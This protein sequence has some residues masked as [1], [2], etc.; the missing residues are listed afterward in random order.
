MAVIRRFANNITQTSGIYVGGRN[1]H[2]YQ[3]FDNL[4]NLKN[5]SGSVATCSNIGSAGGTW[6]R[7]ATLT[8]KNFGFNLPQYAKI[9]KIVIGYSQ[10]KFTYKGHAY[11]TLNAPLITLLNV[12][13][14]SSRGYAVPVAHTSFTKTYNVAPTPAQVNSPNF[15]VV[16]NYPANTRAD[17]GGMKLGYVWIE[18]EYEDLAFTLNTNIINDD[19][20]YRGDFF[21]VRVSLSN[22]SKA[23]IDYSTKVTIQI[24]LG[25]EFVG[26][27]SGQGNFNS[28]SANSYTWISSMNSNFETSAVF[29]VR[30][31]DTGTKNILLQETSTNISSRVSVFVKEDALQVGMDIPDNVVEDDH[32][33]MK[34]SAK[35]LSQ[36]NTDEHVY[37]QFPDQFTIHQYWLDSDHS[38]QIDSEANSFDWVPDT[39]NYSEE[40]LYIEA[41][42]NSADIFTYY[43]GKNSSFTSEDEYTIK[44]RP[45]ELTVPFFSML[46]LDEETCSRMGNG[47][48]YTASSFIKIIIGVPDL[49]LLE[50]YGYNYRFGIFNSE[51]GEFSSVADFENYV[52]S[53]TVWSDTI[54]SADEIA[55]AKVEFKYDENCPVI[56]VWTGEYLESDARAM[57]IQYSTPILIESEYYN[58]VEEAGLFPNPFKA[59]LSNED[60]AVT[61]LKSQLKSN[62]M[63]FYDY[64]V[65][66]L[67]TKDEIVIEGI[68][69]HLN[70]NSDNPCSLLLKLYTNGK[71]GERSLNISQETDEKVIGGKF[72]LWGLDFEDFKDLNNLEIELGLLN[73]FQ[74]DTYLEINNVYI[75]VHYLVLDWESKVKCWINGKDLR[76]Y[77]AFIQ[78]VEIPG[79]LD[80]KVLYHQ[81]KGSDTN[82]PYRSNITSKDIKIELDLLDCSLEDNTIFLERLSKLIRNERDSFNRPILN[83]IEFSHYPDQVFEF[84]QEKAIEVENEFTNYN[85]ELTLNV[86]SGTC[87]SKEAITSHAQGNN[88]SLTRVAPIIQ[89]IP[90]Q[91]EIT[92]TEDVSK[93]NFIIRLASLNPNDSLLV[94]CEKRKAVTLTKNGDGTFTETDV[95]DKVDWSS[96]W[97]TIEGEYRFTCGDSGNIQSVSF[98]ER[99]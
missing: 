97:F 59:L 48:S 41:S 22:L 58:G 68:S 43:I 69:V 31:V 81:V 47:I 33:L 49:S 85:C 95:T 37:I 26:K 21:D 55:E 6:N 74:H 40:T 44:V 11:P 52:L 71:V 32:F 46:E 8:F 89:L 30:C 51:I 4:Q 82:I 7:P 90:L 24:P 84:V 38:I 56:F 78:S 64:V 96:D 15:G 87:R 70:V 10:S 5:S 93:Q 73:P 62:N 18:I 65:G 80:S 60:F 12:A 91:E 61:E 27:V 35:T 3:T 23:R 42:V 14:C 29:R 19:E 2:K 25:L 1:P 76:Y 20:K 57:E 63:R 13:N 66:G 54:A 75:K 83:T 88:A 9:K 67:E 77:N 72:D 99:W 39:L 92:V 45:S 36:R 94:D 50:T 28:T 34:I 53:E 98:Y 16:L 17:I 86:P 79:G